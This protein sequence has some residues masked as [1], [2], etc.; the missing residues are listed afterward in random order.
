MANYANETLSVLWSRS[1]LK[2]KILIGHHSL[3]SF[4]IGKTF[5]KRYKDEITGRY[6]GLHFFGPT[7]ETDYTKSLQNIIKLAIDSLPPTLN[8]STESA[9]P[10]HNR[11]I[12]LQ[13]GN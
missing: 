5:L 9:I 11:F 12:V 13:Q 4:G 7:G 10:V 1:P 3:H 2:H 6:D 8:F